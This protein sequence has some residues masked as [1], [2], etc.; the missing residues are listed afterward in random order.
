MTT[1]RTSAHGIEH[2]FLEALEDVVLSPRF[3]DRLLDDA[4]D[5]HDAAGNHDAL[6]REA[7]ALAVEVANLTRGI[8]AGHDIPALVEALRTRDSRLRKLRAE[9]SQPVVS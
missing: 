7:E 5:A 2:V 3:I 8:A 4:F 6:Q 1:T 9:L